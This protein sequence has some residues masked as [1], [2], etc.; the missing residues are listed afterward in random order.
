[1]KRRSVRR[2]S[3]RPIA[4]P[5]RRHSRPPAESVGR[6]PWFTTGALLASAVLQ[7]ALPTASS[8]ADLRR[9]A[10]IRNGLASVDLARRNSARLMPP[11]LPEFGYRSDAP[12]TGVL[13]GQAGDSAEFTFSISP[14]RLQDVLADFSRATGTEISFGV[15]EL[16]SI[17][18]PGVMG[19]HTAERA[20]A[21]IVLGT[22]TA[23]RFTGDRRALIELPTQ[24]ESV[25]VVARSVT[26]S[27]PKYVV[28][29][30]DIPQTVAVITRAV[31]ETQAV[32]TLSEALRNVPG[33]TMQAGEGGGASNTSGDMFNLRGF[34]ASNSI[35]VDG[36]RD[37]GLVS[38][39]T[40]NLEQVEVFM[41]PS[42]ADVGRGTAAGYVN[43]QTKA[44]RLAS[45]QSVL[46]S[47]GSADQ[48]RVAADFNARLPI[49]DA[50]SWA[51]HSAV[52]VN[53]LWQDSG[54]P[55]RQYATR[56][57][58]SVAPSVALGLQTRTRVTASAQ[59]VRQ[60]NVPDYGVPGAAWTDAP[61]APT[62]VLASRPVDQTN[63]Y[64]SPTSDYDDASQN[65][66]LA[67]LE[68]DFNGSLTLRNQTR[69]N[70]TR[71]EAVISAV[72]NVT[73][74]NPE[75]NLVTLTRQGNLRENRI[76]SN[77][78]SL[79]G[80]FMTGRARHAATA[81]VELT[82]EEQRAPGLTGLGTK[83]PVDIFSPDVNAPVSEFALDRSA[84]YSDGD[85]DTAALYASDAV[86]LFSRWQVSGAVRAE[87]YAATFR[88]LTT[89][90]VLT[91]ADAS[92][93]LVSGKAG[94]LFRLS[95][96]AN[97]YASMG[98][99]KT[100]P[101]TVNFTLSAQA[102]NQNN[103]NV[104]PQESTN[105]EAGGKWDIDN[106]RL[107]MSAAVFRTLNRN[108]IY[109]VDATAI[110]PSFNQDDEQL[111]KGASLGVSGRIT[112]GWNIFAN[113]AYLDSESRSQNSVNNGRRLPLTPVFSGSLWTTYR[114]PRGLTV[115]GGLRHTGAVYVNAANTIRVPG[116]RLI[117][118]V[119][120]YPVNSQLSLRVNVS[121]MTNATY[122][123][124]VSNNG[125]RYNPGYSRAVLATL[126]FRF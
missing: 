23:A 124:N 16:G 49:A 38:R 94:T 102:N 79:V 59:V 126:S 44:P 51:G 123:R 97:L 17:Q 58:R 37:D 81:G 33:I 74:F 69:Y 88:S 12:S 22:G 42:G 70:Q 116:Y 108:V 2:Y 14:G 76:L 86:D 119:A 82:R 26:V 13:D 47:V 27:S 18:S 113:A 87:R 31:M 111:V 103:P 64:G 52:R 83:A 106:G 101:G 105:V 65:T 35:F 30:R 60:D 53:A 34:N 122:I 93:T 63:F 6:A 78:S 92:D 45:Q 43:M 67:R 89:A 91:D 5:V 4:H 46:L 72:L 19:R 61:L 11:P 104:R 75:T 125:G 21:L 90:D 100:P 115:G 99:G 29:V 85:V 36:V 120:E 118:L 25:N 41:G 3:S 1:M 109:T 15:P 8:A 56:E 107:S 117:D 7:G 77:I 32:T 66:V 68:H 24:S 9:F 50:D 57:N 96:A 112:E 114:L 48:K 84:A 95:R 62:T 71:R 28:P 10:T 98:T 73:A 54:T 121:N 20:L 39:D 80:R 55:G 110:P 40:F